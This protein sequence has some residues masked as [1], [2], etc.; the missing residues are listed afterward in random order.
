VDRVIPLPEAARSASRP[1]PPDDRTRPPFPRPRHPN[2]CLRRTRRPPRPRRP[3][4]AR[5]SLRRT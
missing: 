1:P 3:A 2:P 5:W 4:T